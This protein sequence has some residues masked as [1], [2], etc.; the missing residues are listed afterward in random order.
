MDPFY[1]DAKQIAELESLRSKLQQLRDSFL[2]FLQATDPRFP[3][4]ASWPE[5]LNKFNILVAR[6][7]SLNRVLSENH[8]SALRKM[9]LH[10]QEP[11]GTDQEQ[12]VLAVLLRTKLVPEVEKAQEVLIREAETCY[13]AGVTQALQERFVGSG[14]PA[15]ELK[16]WKVTLVKYRS[17]TIALLPCLFSFKE[18]LQ[19]KAEAHDAVCLSAEQSLEKHLDQYRPQLKLRIVDEAE[20]RAAAAEPPPQLSP[21]RAAGLLKEATTDLERLMRFVSSGTAG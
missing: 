5:I 7:V 1:D 9:V 12:Q 10:P 17:Q 4:T 6:Y 11:V 13:A 21:A 20:V 2:P 19:S 14:P 3:F 18:S 15:E 8:L 16:L